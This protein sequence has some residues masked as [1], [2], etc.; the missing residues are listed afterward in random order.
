M[1]AP[2]APQLRPAPQ[3]LPPQQGCPTP[4]HFPQT[5]ATPPPPQLRPALQVLPAQHCSP[6]S[7][8]ELQVPD[9]H[10]RPA[11]R[12]VLPAQ[13]ASPLPPHPHFPSM[14]QVRGEVQAVPVA[15]HAWPCPPHLMLHTPLL[16]P[17]HV[18][19]VT[20][21]VVLLE[22]LT[23]QHGWLGPAQ[24]PT[25]V[26]CPEPEFFKQ[27]FADEQVRPEPVQIEPLQQG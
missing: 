26:S 3:V 25:G 9:V 20:Q 12:Q 15:Q 11:M 17:E 13:H 10:V 6:T 2:P 14:P 16:E 1:P 8:H 24:P 18:R 23:L 22:G 21:R 5:L 19:P 27:T 7:P 4:P